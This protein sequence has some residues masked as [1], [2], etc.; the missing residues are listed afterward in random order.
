MLQEKLARLESVKT[1]LKQEFFGIDD[2]IDKIID[3]MTAWYTYP[4]LQTIPT[5][6]VLTGLTGVGKTDVVRR[7]VTLLELEDR[8]TY[9][10]LPELVNNKEYNTS[11]FSLLW[12][13]RNVLPDNPAVLVIDEVHLARTRDE[14]GNDKSRNYSDIWD[15]FSD[16]TLSATSYRRLTKDLKENYENIMR[17]IRRNDR[18]QKPSDAYKWFE[19]N[20]STKEVDDYYFYR[21]KSMYCF[22]S[23]SSSEEVDLLPCKQFLEKVQEYITNPPKQELCISYKKLLIFIISNLDELYATASEIDTDHTNI[24]NLYTVSKQVNSYEVREAFLHRFMPEQV[25]RFGNNYILYPSLNTEAYYKIIEKSLNKLK[26]NYKQVVNIDIEFDATVHDF[27]FTNCVFP[28]QGARNTISGIQQYIE[29]NLPKL[30]MPILGGTVLPSTYTISYKDEYLVVTN[31]KVLNKVKVVGDLDKCRK[32]T[33]VYSKRLTAIHE[34]GHAVAYMAL[35]GVVPNFISCA[36]SASGV[37]GQAVTPDPLVPTDKFLKNSICVC[38]GSV[39]A[40]QVLFGTTTV[41]CSGDIERASQEAVQVYRKLSGQ[42]VR[43]S[44]HSTHADLF[45]EDTSKVNRKTTRLLNKSFRK[46]KRI[47]KK[48]KKLVIALAEALAASPTYKLVNEEIAVIANL[49]S[50]LSVRVEDY[51]PTVESGLDKVIK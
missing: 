9:I 46:T 45:I 13:E 14:Q 37:G 47:I 5:K 7:L 27:I 36:R 11:V 41:T 6:I 10:N 18:R 43:V 48:H 51:T 25:S 19:D 1:Q 23:S 15:L 34:A 20:V 49:H 4:E 17:S 29:S 16:G 28:M 24:D 31:K 32:E 38:L 26:E 21:M 2:E 30:F 40:L 12:E 33:S 39:A 3:S 50:K 44:S 35:T 22:L 42:G 8:Y